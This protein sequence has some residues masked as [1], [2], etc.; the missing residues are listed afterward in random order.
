MSNVDLAWE[1]TSMIIA[2]RGHQADGRATTT[3]DEM[4]HEPTVLER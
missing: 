2:Q 4:P 1:V 3:S